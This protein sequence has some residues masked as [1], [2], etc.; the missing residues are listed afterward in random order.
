VASVGTRVLFRDR[1]RRNG[2][3]RAGHIERLLRL[4]GRAGMR[5]V[6]SEAAELGAEIA[7]GKVHFGC[8]IAHVGR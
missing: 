6:A 5:G 3:I 8:S 2:L 4:D 1:L 7:A